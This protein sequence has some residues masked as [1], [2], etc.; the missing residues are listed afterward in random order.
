MKQNQKL[1]KQKFIDRCQR[2]LINGKLQDLYKSDL[3]QFSD[4]DILENKRIQI[5]GIPEFLIPEKNNFFE[6]ENAVKLF[7]VYKNISR[8]QATDTRIW[9]YLAHVTYWKYMKTRWPI[10]ENESEKKVVNHILQH[11]YMKSSDSKSISRHGLASLWW[12][13]FIT[14]DKNREDPFELTKE[15]FSKQDYKRIILEENISFYK[16]LVQAILEYVI[17]NS[18]IFEKYGEDKRRFLA[19]KLNFITGYKIL[20]SLNKNKIKTIINEYKRDIMSVTP[21]TTIEI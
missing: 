3:F 13:A 1:F 14:Y 2:D 18:G 4:I 5:D 19:E 17:E 6:Y 8:T 10:P 9:T 15:F 21:K 20:S 16:P 7:Q 12:G 11:W